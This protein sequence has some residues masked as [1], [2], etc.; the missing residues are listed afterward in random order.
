MITRMTDRAIWTLGDL[1]VARAAEVDWSQFGTGYE[2]ERKMVELREEAVLETKRLFDEAGIPL[3]ESVDVTA[4]MDGQ[5]VAVSLWSRE[6]GLM[7]LPPE[8][9]KSLFKG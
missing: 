5:D 9:K 4:L 6:M 1:L 7:A 3:D 2:R 8:L